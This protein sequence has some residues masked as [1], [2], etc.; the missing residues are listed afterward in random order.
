MSFLA[1]ILLGLLSGFLGSKLMGGGGGI[2]Y[3][4]VLGVVGSVVGG[5]LFGLFGSA[6]VTGFN[7]WSLLVATVGAVSLIALKRAILGRSGRLAPR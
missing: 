5:F 1:W 3:D 2:L 6:G 7:A 4:L